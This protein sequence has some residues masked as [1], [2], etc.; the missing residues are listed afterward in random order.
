MY[1]RLTRQI[2]AMESDLSGKESI[3]TL[4]KTIERL[5]KELLQQKCIAND[6]IDKLAAHDT[7][8]K[9][10]ISILQKESGLK[11]DQV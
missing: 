2:E 3:E 11:I 10:A 4:Q 7:A 9:R 5:D 8:A 6:A 1:L